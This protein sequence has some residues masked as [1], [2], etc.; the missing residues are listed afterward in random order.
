M[1]AYLSRLLAGNLLKFSV[2]TIF[3]IWS[4][5]WPEFSGRQYQRAKLHTTVTKMACN[6]AECT[7]AAFVGMSSMAKPHKI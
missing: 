1:R 4:H 5:E 6:I 3:L 7:S 2:I